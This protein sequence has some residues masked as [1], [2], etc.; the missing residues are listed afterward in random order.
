MEQVVQ[1]CGG[2]AD[3]VPAARW[4]LGYKL[5]LRCGESKARQERKAWTV[6][7]LHKS[8]YMLFTDRALLTGINNKGGIVR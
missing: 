6:A 5:C 1:E 3:E 4:A 8:N 7:P 2:C